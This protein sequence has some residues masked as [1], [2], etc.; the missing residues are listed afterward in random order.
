MRVIK[1]YDLQQVTMQSLIDKGL[2]LPADGNK[3]WTASLFPKSKELNILPN[4]DKDRIITQIDDSL[5]SDF[6]VLDK[7]NQNVYVKRGTGRKYIKSVEIGDYNDSVKRYAQLDKPIDYNA[8]AKKFLNL[9]TYDFSL[10]QQLN[11]SVELIHQPGVNINDFL[12][13]AR[14]EM[15]ETPIDHPHITHPKPKPTAFKHNNK[16]IIEHIFK[17]ALDKGV[18]YIYCINEYRPYSMTQ[19]WTT[20]YVYYTIKGS[21]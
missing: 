7:Q 10:I 18:K 14:M 9:P 8:D 19:E 1:P 3:I 11:T 13:P 21:Y 2:I 20:P 17:W 4:I 12:P 15:F 5:F 16:A 6:I